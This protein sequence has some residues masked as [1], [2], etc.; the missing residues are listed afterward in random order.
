MKVI[1]LS[2]GVALASA[3]SIGFAQTDPAESARAAIVALEEAAGE[4]RAAEGARDRVAALTQ[5]VRA[6]EFGLDAMREGLRRATIREAALKGVFDAE[7]DRLAKLL[8]VLQSIERAP[9]PVTL[10]HPAGPLG[11]ARAGM[12]LTDVV[13][14]LQAEA[15]TLRGQLE[16]VSVLRQLQQSAVS[17]LEDGLAGVQDARAALSQAVSDRTDLPR[18]FVVDE[19]KMQALINSTETLESFAS[20]LMEIEPMSAESGIEA[21][22]GLTDRKGTLTLPVLGR[23]L[24]RYY[25]P[26]AAGI[27]RPGIILATRPLSL[28]VAPASGTIRYAGPL[29]DYGQVAILEP[30][31][32]ILLILAGMGQV[33]GNVGEVLPEGA[34]IGLM[35][36]EN[37]GTQAFLIQSGQGSNSDHSETLYIELRENGTPVDPENWFAVN[38]D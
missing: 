16:E 30:Q 1:A 38:K 22:V 29:L 20:G 4:L 12:I 32:G 31:E 7:S 9:A 10:I 19:A 36:G 6:Y 5:T 27:Q 3:G 13:P 17:V 25:E 33:Y 37:P 2:I 21:P 11:A 24:R 26:D 35:G 8:G 34:P 23:V 18:R 14:T 28:V 15:T